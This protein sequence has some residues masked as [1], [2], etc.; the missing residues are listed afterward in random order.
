MCEELS[1]SAAGGRE[2][3]LDWAPCSALWSQFLRSAVLGIRLAACPAAP[4]P[5]QPLCPPHL[6][7]SLLLWSPG[8]HVCLTPLLPT[9]LEPAPFHFVSPEH[10]G[11]GCWLPGGVFSLPL[12][13]RRNN[14]RENCPGSC[15]FSAEQL[16]GSLAAS[17][18]YFSQS[19]CKL[20]F[21]T[22]LP[23]FFLFFTEAMSTK[24]DV[25]TSHSRT[26]S[27]NTLYDHTALD[28][29]WHIPS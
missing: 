4:S 2:P 24:M 23:F 25:D 28:Q 10:Q 27:S 6:M 13:G 20:R 18:R 26:F 14:S 22:F 8:A 5:T 11:V 17:S 15:F 1:E 16:L 19:I 3:A 21:F 12:D 7:C 29:I 9:A